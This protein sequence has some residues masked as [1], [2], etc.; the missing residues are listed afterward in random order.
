MTEAVIRSEEELA[1]EDQDRAERLSAVA[2]RLS[3]KALI[4]KGNVDPGESGHLT[5]AIFNVLWDRE[6]Q[7]RGK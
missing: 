2:V 3:R 7:R 1:K 5:V 4:F 6:M